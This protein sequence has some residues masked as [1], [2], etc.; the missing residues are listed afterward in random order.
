MHKT[1]EKRDDEYLSM[2]EL[3]VND[4]ELGMNPQMRS[5]NLQARINEVIINSPIINSPHLTRKLPDSPEPER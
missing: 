3:K 1:P 5:M 2:D 4:K